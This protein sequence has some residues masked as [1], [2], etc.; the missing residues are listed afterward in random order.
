MQTYGWKL[1]TVYH[2]P[3]NFGSQTHCD[4]GDIM[5]SIW[6]VT[7]CD[8]VFK[9]LWYFIRGSPSQKV[10]ILPCLVAVGLVQVE[11]WSIYFVTRPHKSKDWRIMK[12]YERELLIVSH[13][14]AKFGGHWHCMDKC[15]KCGGYTH[16][17]IRDKFLVCQVKTMLL[18][19]HATYVGM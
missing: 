9:G 12:L 14:T 8:H 16:C 13:H 15:G 18:K 7:S 17:G 3:D 11:I 6:H 4:S 2:H 19:G 5:F 1:L 10:T